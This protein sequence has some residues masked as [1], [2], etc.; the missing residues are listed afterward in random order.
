MDNQLDS[1]AAI[2]CPES[3]FSGCGVMLAGAGYGEC[4]TAPETYWVDL[5]S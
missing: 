3:G 1:S 5:N 2:R 4:Y